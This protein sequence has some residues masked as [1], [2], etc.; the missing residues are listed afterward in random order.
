MNEVIEAM[1]SRETKSYNNA[2]LFLTRQLTGEPLE[3]ALAKLKAEHEANLARYRTGNFAYNPEQEE[4]RQK[5]DSLDRMLSINGINQA[6]YD[7][8][9]FDL[10]QEYGV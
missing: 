8:M 6:T 10:K 9:L 4:Y 7:S 1:V 5:L 3:T 2:Y